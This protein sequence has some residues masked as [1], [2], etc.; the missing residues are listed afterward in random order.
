MNFFSAVKP[1]V[2]QENDNNNISLI[3]HL[4]NIN[5]FNR[6]TNSK[7]E[8]SKRKKIIITGINKNSKKLQDSKGIIREIPQ[9]KNKKLLENSNVYDDSDFKQKAEELIDKLI[10]MDENK[11]TDEDTG[12]QK[13]KT[14]KDNFS[15]T[16]GKFLFLL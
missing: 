14:L 5:K 7:L 4:P 13:E 1:E 2:K 15:V 12:Y 3:T 16:K 9:L 6:D 11:I 10:D 8:L